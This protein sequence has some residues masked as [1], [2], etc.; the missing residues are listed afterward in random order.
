MEHGG[1]ATLILID[2][3]LVGLVP[4]RAKHIVY[5]LT[6]SASYLT[7]SIVDAVLEIGNGEW[8]PAYEDDALYPVL[9]WNNDQKGATIVCAFVICVLSPCLFYG[10][11]ALSLKRASPWSWSSRTDVT[12]DDE[13]THHGC[14]SGNFDGSRRPL[15]PL[16]GDDGPTTSESAAPHYKVM[17]DKEVV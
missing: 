10:C 11:W 16:D 4:V 5:L 1:I 13:F 17:E 15:Y 9:N 6:V 8:G 2:G 12:E 7:W 14:C 3:L